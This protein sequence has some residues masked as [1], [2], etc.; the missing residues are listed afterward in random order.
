MIFFNRLIS[1]KYLNLVKLF[2]DSKFNIKLFISSK[3]IGFI[4]NMLPN[5][6]PFLKEYIK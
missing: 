1:S 3:S 4:V 6:F 2:L 5:S